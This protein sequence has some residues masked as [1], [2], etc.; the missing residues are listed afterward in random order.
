MCS[1]PS[2]HPG[3]RRARSLPAVGNAPAAELETLGGSSDWEPTHPLRLLPRPMRMRI[4]TRKSMGLPRHEGASLPSGQRW[5]LFLA[6][7]ALFWIILAQWC[8]RASVVAGTSGIKLWYVDA[9][10]APGL[11]V[12]RL[13]ERDWQSNYWS[14]SD[15]PRGAKRPYWEKLG[16]PPPDSTI[17]IRSPGQLEL[18]QHIIEIG[19]LNEGFLQRYG[20]ETQRRITIDVVLA[21]D[22]PYREF[23]QILDQIELFA[24]QA[25]LGQ[26]HL[27][28]LN[29]RQDPDFY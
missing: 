1:P 3:T 18:D 12:R 17:R 22:A 25:H 9:S 16:V 4:R 27:A 20:V 26:V 19:Q 8:W 24:C 7:G 21:G 28:L 10:L 14:M 5:V 11:C 29:R 6:C 15:F 2:T 13:T 23:V